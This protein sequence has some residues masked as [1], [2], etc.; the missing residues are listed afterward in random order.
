[1]SIQRGEKAIVSVDS[2]TNF[3]AT[4][5]ERWKMTGCGWKRNGA[6][7]K[8]LAE[9]TAAVFAFARINPSSSSFSSSK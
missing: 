9:A 7:N 2:Q 4:L 5:K 6:K 3:P 8:R 1:L